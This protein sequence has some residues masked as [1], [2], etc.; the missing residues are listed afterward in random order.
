MSKELQQLTKEFN[1]HNVKVLRTN[2]NLYQTSIGTV[3][4]PFLKEITTQTKKS[5][6]PS[7]ILV[8]IIV[9]AA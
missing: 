4:A 1:N 7:V 9:E 5:K 2:L 8:A 6:S 3:A